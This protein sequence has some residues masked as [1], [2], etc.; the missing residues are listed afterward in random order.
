MS[1]LNQKIIQLLSSRHYQKLAAYRPPFQPLNVLG[2][3]HRELSF[4]SVFAW[5][6]SDPENKKFRQGF[7]L[8][9]MR[10]LGL[11]CAV[12]LDE[13]IIVRREFGDDQA[14]R[15]DVFV[16]L[17]KLDLVVAIEIKVKAGEGE[18]Q[19]SRYQEFLL[20]RYRRQ[21]NRAVV[22][23]TPF[24]RSATTAS[25]KSDVRVFPVSWKSIADILDGC[26]GHG[27]IHDF[28]VQF[29]KHIRRSVLMH[30]EEKQIVIDFLKEG[31]NA[32]TIRKVME[33]VPDLGE[34]E[35]TEKYKCIVADVLSVNV[36]DLELAP[37][38]TRGNT[39][40]LKIRVKDWNKAGIPITL[41]LWN[42]ET[43]ALRLLVFSNHYEGN[44]ISLNNFSSTSNGVVGNY[45]KLPGWSWHSVIATDGDQVVPEESIIGYEIFHDKFWDTVKVRLRK[46]I[47]YLLPLIQ[48]YV[49]AVKETDR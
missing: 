41:M 10:K 44:A 30:R 28:R 36:S 19:I 22:Y 49:A 23:I 13:P 16:Q 2:I 42:Y 12:G 31:D 1:D 18:Y 45:P 15:I 46:Q 9:V 35:Y 11:H 39:R 21:N 6:L 29:S 14:G 26:T 25:D 20:K 48:N 17:E 43:T 37:H 33:Y 24:G 8:L 32:K 7:L 4:S 40:E 38:R 3:T 5:L 27:E 34:E 47:G